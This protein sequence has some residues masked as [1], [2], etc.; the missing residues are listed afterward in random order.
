MHVF[1]KRAGQGKVR[2]SK[3]TSISYHYGL[4]HRIWL[5]ND[6]TVLTLVASLPSLTTAK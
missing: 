3:Q 5:L 1:A 4:F 6:K 2:R